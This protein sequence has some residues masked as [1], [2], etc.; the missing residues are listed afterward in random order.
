MYGE[1]L[2]VA[3]VVVLAVIAVIDLRTRRAPNAIVYPATLAGVVAS[4]PLG[5]EHRVEAWLG[6]LAAFAVMT[7]IY[8]VGRGKMG[9]GD[10]KTSAL[11]GLAVGVH[12]VFTMLVTTFLAGSL[13]AIVVLALRLRDRKDAVAFTPFILIGVLVSMFTTPGYLLS[14]Q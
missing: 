4:I 7:L 5:A 1:A 10:A 11:A 9:A 3:Y 14:Q 13:V 12:G 2:A 8:I 6:G